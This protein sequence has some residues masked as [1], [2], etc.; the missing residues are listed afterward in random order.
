MAMEAALQVAGSCNSQVALLELVDMSIGKAVVF[1]DENSQVELNLT[2][3]IVHDPGKTGL[4]TL[5]FTIHSCLAQENDLSTS[6]TGQM[7]ITLSSADTPEPI[8]P[9][10]EVE[11]PGM[12]SVDVDAFYKELGL[13]GYNY[14]KEFRGIRSMKRA[15]SRAIGTIKFLSLKDEIRDQLLVLHPAPLDTVFHA[16]IGAYSSPG[17]KRLRT[18]YVPTHIGRM[19]L[20]PSLCLSAVENGT[21]ELNFNTDLTYDLGDSIRADITAFES[22]QK[23]L[24][25]VENLT[26]KPLASLSATTDH[27]IFTKWCWGPLMPDKILDDPQ[28]WA[29]KQDE[30]VIR[31][32]ERT[33]HFYIRTFLSDFATEDHSNVIHKKQITWFERVVRESNRSPWYH[34]S[35]EADTELE[36]QNICVDHMYHPQLRLVQRVGENLMV[37]MRENK[38]PFDILQADDNLLTEYYTS[39]LSIGPILLYAQKLVSQIAHRY[40]TMDILE[41]GSGT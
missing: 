31:I 10:P 20:A 7:V 12:T 40:P 4:I 41:I 35:W 15:D 11:H 3:H 26:F 32:A 33:A 29:T 19:T 25:Q 5:N 14:S 1:G 28:H 17:D 6:V 2:A 39:K 21:D 38:N 34:P 37:I 8:L 27:N 18:L 23:T 36:I 13:L 16:V 22:Q 9:P 30:E 24:F